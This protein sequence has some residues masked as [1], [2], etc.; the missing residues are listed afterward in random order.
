MSSLFPSRLDS[1]MKTPPESLAHSIFISSQT[2]GNHEYIDGIHENILWENATGSSSVSQILTTISAK[3]PLSSDTTKKAIL[4][5][6][7]RIINKIGRI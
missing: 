2:V 3:E 5:L 6:V 1:G 7:K 4:S